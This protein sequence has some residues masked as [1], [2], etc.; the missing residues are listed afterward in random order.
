MT[1]W[2]RPLVLF[3]LFIDGMQ[4]FVLLFCLLFSYQFQLKFWQDK[5]FSYFYFRCKALWE[6]VTGFI[7]L[8]DS[9]LFLVSYGHFYSTSSFRRSR[10][11]DW[12]SLQCRVHCCR[13]GACCCCRVSPFLRNPYNEAAWLSSHQN[14]GVFVFWAQFLIIASSVPICCF[15]RKTKSE[16]FSLRIL[17]LTTILSY[18]K[19]GPQRLHRG[20]IYKSNVSIRS[21]I[22]FDYSIFKKNQ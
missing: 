19:K 6:S 22:V 5:H 18:L 4:L 7:W 20:G 17:T 1:C 14:W 15:T 16:F 21:T 11:K 3:I 10:G 2:C 13:V 9:V 12:Y 8:S